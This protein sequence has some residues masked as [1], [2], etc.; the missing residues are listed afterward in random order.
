MAKVKNVEAFCNVC[1]ATT[2]M[3]LAGEANSGSGDFSENKRW[4]KCKKCKQMIIIDLN[5]IAEIKAQK[6]ASGIKTED[7]KEYSPKSTFEVGESIYHKNWDDYG[8]VIGK[9]TTSNGQNTIL[10]EF[11]KNGQKKLLE[12]LS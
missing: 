12:A 5:E 4:A 7:S 9:E 11:Q 10:V 3:E 2:K 8:K 1:G 6:S